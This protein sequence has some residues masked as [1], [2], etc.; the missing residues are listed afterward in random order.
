[1]FKKYHYTFCLKF[2]LVIFLGMMAIYSESEKLR[3]DYTNLFVGS[4]IALFINNKKKPPGNPP[5]SKGS[6]DNIS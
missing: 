4:T 3:Y 5:A 2:A 6:R 1:M